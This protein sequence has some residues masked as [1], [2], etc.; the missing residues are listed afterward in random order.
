MNDNGDSWLDDLRALRS[1]SAELQQEIDAAQAEIDEVLALV[2]AGA[3][4]MTYDRGGLVDALDFDPE[5]RPPL[6]TPQLQQEINM[7]LVRANNDRPS[8]QPGLWDEPGDVF[9]ESP[10]IQQL[11]KSL[12]TGVLPEMAEI[13]NDFNQVVVKAAW[14]NVV[15]ITCDLRWLSS[16]PDHLISE[17]VVRMSRIAA[18]E[19]D[20]SGRFAS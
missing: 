9:L 8:Y 4:T 6:T 5:L 15:A 20:D 1:E 12:A 16:T 10:Y 7:A 14:G 19:T 3:A 17:E 11:M 13:V 2:G 18:I